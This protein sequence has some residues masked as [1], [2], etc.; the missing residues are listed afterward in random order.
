MF[1]YN[2]SINVY[3]TK[4]KH[5]QS[6]D[7][8]FCFQLEIPFLGKFGPKTQNY[9]FKL[10]FCTQ[11]NSNMQNSMMMFTF[12]VFDWK[13]LFGQ[14]WS[15]KSKL[16]VCAE[17]SHQINLNMHNY[18]VNMWCPLFLFQTRKTLFGQIWSKKSKLSVKAEIWYQE[19]NLNMRNSMMMFTFSVF[20][21]K[22]LSWANLVQK[23][24]ILCSK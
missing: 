23:F 12:S 8:L 3:Y 19:T 7:C 13:Y 1:K 4:I 2:S 17:I 21:H 20:D 18:V 14:I 10:K 5:L 9:Q 22:Y 16:A 15:K 6:S 11:T 24:K